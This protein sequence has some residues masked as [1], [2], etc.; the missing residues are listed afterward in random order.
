MSKTN[1]NIQTIK[2][3]SIAYRLFNTGKYTSY[4]ELYKAVRSEMNLTHSEWHS[5]KFRNRLRMQVHNGNVLEIPNGC[6]HE[7]LSNIESTATTTS[8]SD[9]SS[10]DITDRLKHE[11]ER[12]GLPIE[13][14]SSYKWVNHQGQ[15]ALNIAFHPQFT[16]NLSTEHKIKEFD[17]E[18]KKLYEHISKLTPKKTEGIDAV[19]QIT[20]LHV[21]MNPNK[22]GNSIWNTSWTKDDIIDCALEIVRIIHECEDECGGFSSITLALTGDIVDG[23]NA[24]TT[25]GGH[26]LPQLMN[27]IEQERVAL[28]FFECII[29][30]VKDLAPVSIKAV[31]NSN[32]GGHFEHLVLN[33]LKSLCKWKH[34]I[35]MELTNKMAMAT[36]IGQTRKPL[37][38]MHGKDQEFATRPFAPYIEDKD[39]YKVEAIIDALGVKNPVLKPIVMK[40]DSHIFCDQEKKNFYWISGGACSPDSD[41]CKM[42]FFNPKA[43]MITYLSYNSSTDKLSVSN[44]NLKGSN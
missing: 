14:V 19:F 23:Y 16:E 4:K 25:R 31:S 6:K 21:G 10:T 1:E 5:P 43:G 27:N 17:L 20:D 9:Y 41:W 8:T 42:N 15:E 18:A 24:E 34:G 36:T 12:F 11:C 7:E 28:L 38:L 44:I 13:A 30:G 32:H 37:V 40:G 35:E 3:Q 39:D 29:Q 26:K 2:A 22:D 33:H